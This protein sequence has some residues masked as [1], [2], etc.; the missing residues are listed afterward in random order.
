MVRSDLDEDD[1]L[2][3]D[4]EEWD[5]AEAEAEPETEVREVTMFDAAREEEPEEPDFDE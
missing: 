2:V 4:A 5:D 3:D 1:D